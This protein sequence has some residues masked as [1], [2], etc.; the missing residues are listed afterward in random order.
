[1]TG[2]G[3]VVGGGGVTVA[4]GSGIGNAGVPASML[5]ASVASVVAIETLE[6]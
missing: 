3:V 1:V 2:V 6:Q 5:N 4:S